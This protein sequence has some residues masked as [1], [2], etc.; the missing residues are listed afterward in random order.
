MC[1]YMNIDVNVYIDEHE[2]KWI[3]MPKHGCACVCTRMNVCT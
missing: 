2:Y 3:K 1:A